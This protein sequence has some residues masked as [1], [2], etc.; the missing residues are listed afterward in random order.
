VAHASHKRDANARPR[1]RGF[2]VAATLATATTTS[3][4]G[5]GIA[6]TQGTLA[7]ESLTGVTGLSS[8]EIANRAALPISRN[9]ARQH[10][11]SIG[12]E[13]GIQKLENRATRRAERK[14]NRATRRAERKATKAAISGATTKLWTTTELNLWTGPEADAQQKGVIKEAKKVLVTGRKSGSREEVVID[15]NA[16]WVS[17]GY[18]ST[19][20]PVQVPNGLSDKPCPDPSVEDGITDDAVVVYRSVC[21][22]FP[23]IT[24]YIGWDNHG[25]HT[26]GRAIDIMTSD[27]ELGTAIADYLVAN[28]A[29]LNLYDVIWRQR[30]WTAERASEGWRPMSDRGSATANH[31]DHVHVATNG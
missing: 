1:S 4:I 9:T 21:N 2:W 29:E 7:P 20:K 24:T 12:F 31:M 19:D 3:A 8:A 15:G 28:A 16:F 6:S 27:V 26:S 5:I 22:A 10:G 17:F 25:E 11:P 13:K 14:E 18:L 30:I 23:E